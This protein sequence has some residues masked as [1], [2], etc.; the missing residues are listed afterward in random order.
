MNEKLY[1]CQSCSIALPDY[2]PCPECGSREIEC[3]HPNG[4]VERLDY[5]LDLL[6]VC[7]VTGYTPDMFEQF[8]IETGKDGKKI[9]TVYFLDELN[10]IVTDKWSTVGSA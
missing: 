4:T 5:L 2:S 10:N 3:L 9:I 8:N 6:T 1:N 7:N